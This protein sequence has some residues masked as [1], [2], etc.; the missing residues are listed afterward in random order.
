M[1]EKFEFFNSLTGEEITTEDYEKT[2]K[3]FDLLK[4]KNMRE[5]ME[6]YCQLDVFLLA[7]VFFQFREETMI[8]FNIDPCNYISLPG[9]G[10]D[11]F[12]K[13]SEI[14]LDS[15]HSGK[16]CE[17]NLISSFYVVIR[18]TTRFCGLRG[19]VLSVEKTAVM[20]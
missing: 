4:F 1:P 15:L 17:W 20:L 13:K 5:Y 19:D 7:E 2:K 12:L 3:I 8:N 14:V 6:G 9:M 18:N 11:C 16:K 10:L